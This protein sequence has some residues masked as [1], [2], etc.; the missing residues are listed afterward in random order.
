MIQHLFLEINIKEDKYSGYWQIK[1]TKNFIRVVGDTNFPR[2]R[3]VKR[4][5]SGFKGYYEIYTT[6]TVDFLRLKCEKVAE[7]TFKEIT[8]FN[9]KH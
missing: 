4:I 6:E 8:K 5:C 9:Y 7:D 3:S 1:D 2:W